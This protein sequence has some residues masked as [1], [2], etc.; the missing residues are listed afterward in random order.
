MR[1]KAG[2]LLFVGETMADSLQVKP[3]TTY[4]EQVEILRGRG[5]IIPDTDEAVKILKQVNYYRLSAYMLSLKKKDRFIAGATIGNVYNLYEFDRK[6]RNL[7][8]SALETIE[9]AFR[10]HISYTLAHDMGRWVISMLATFT[11]PPIT[12]AL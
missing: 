12:R 8:M 7:L 11:T 6:L 2:H 1:T 5:L 4:A 3:P 10:T 9:I